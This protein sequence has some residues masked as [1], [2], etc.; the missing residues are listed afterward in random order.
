[1]KPLGRAVRQG[2]AEYLA[3]NFRI[4]ARALS[5]LHLCEFQRL[6]A[7]ALDAP[8]RPAFTMRRKCTALTYELI[9][10]G[11]E[12]DELGGEQDRKRTRLNSSHSCATRMAA[13][14]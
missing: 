8:D 12:G 4:A 13:S 10:P 7:G 14:A 1:M 3:T 11:T 9:G 6:A 2:N 5:H